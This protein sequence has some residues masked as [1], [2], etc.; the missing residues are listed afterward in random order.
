MDSGYYAVLS[1]LV[2]RG[3]A[4][5]T[6][7]NNL[8]NASTNGFRAERDYFR[9]AILGPHA[10]GSQLNAALNNYGV[11]GGNH[12]DLGQGPIT[13]T[14]NPLDVAIE[15]AGFFAVSTKSGTRYTRDGAFARDMNGT[16]ITSR[17]ETVVGTNGK[18]ILLPG[19][20]VE[21]S[22][23]GTVSVAGG[24]AGVLKLVNFPPGNDVVPEGATLFRATDSAAIPATG[25]TLHQGSVEGSNLNVVEGSMHLML[26]QR[27]AEMMQKAL[28]IFHTEFDKTATEELSKV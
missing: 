9:D 24:V 6:A 25:V 21:I 7:A 23:D 5:D 28:S 20:K 27:Q 1:G 12:A 14:G 2:A 13:P 19:G 26:V 15:G 8:A 11:V 17:H 18:P 16:L 22:P 3:Q 4:L 10:G